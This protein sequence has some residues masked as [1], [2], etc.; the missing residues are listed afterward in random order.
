MAREVHDGM[1]RAESRRG[2]P[3]EC[4]TPESYFCGRQNA[5]AAQ[6]KRG[7]DLP[8]QPCQPRGMS[9][10]GMKV[11]KRFLR[12]SLG[13]EPGGRQTR[14]TSSR[15]GGRHFHKLLKREGWHYQRTQHRD[16]DPAD[17]RPD[18]ARRGADYRKDQ[19]CPGY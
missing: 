6:N 7:R 8:G 13:D 9:A 5:Q 2:R 3:N 10:S 17:P 18:V 4:I 16:A 15:G 19:R 12:P 11:T 1:T 14:R